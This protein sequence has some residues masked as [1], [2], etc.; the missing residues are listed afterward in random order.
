M[1][2]TS[3]RSL[4]TLLFLALG[5]VAGSLVIHAES[6]GSGTSA[7]TV[8]QGDKLK[9][10]KSI[11]EGATL[12]APICGTGYCH[13]TGGSGG[14]APRIRGKGLEANDI[15]KAIRNGVGG[16]PMP[17]FKSTYSEEQIWK[18][19]AFVMSPPGAEGNVTI[20]P[21][22]SIPPPIPAP[23][24]VA[25]SPIVGDGQAGKNIFFDSTQPK[26]C[27]A[28]HAVDGVGASIGPDLSAVATRAPKELFLSIILPHDKVEPRYLSTRLTL[29]D[30]DK[31]VGLA[32][33]EREDEVELYDVTELPAVLRTV[34]KKNIVKRE[35]LNESPMPRDYSSIYTMKQ[36]LDLVTYLKS[37]DPKSKS[38]VALKDLF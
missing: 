3:D 27:Q 21:A 4:L 30:G 34:Q 32:K 14:G 15:F 12:F 29:A 23:A 1:K 38:P 25:N 35:S 26:S 13:G 9:D 5:C 10:Q 28:C 20:Q 11:A 7:A 18:L 33:Q 22:T 24:K 16:T 6:L 31:L 8:I 2:L 37:T 19:V 36:L 17:A